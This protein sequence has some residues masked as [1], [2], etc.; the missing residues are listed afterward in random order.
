M[1]SVSSAIWTSGEPV[2]DS[3]TRVDGD[4]VVFLCSLQR[5]SGG[6]SSGRYL[7]V[8]FVVIGRIACRGSRHSA[9]VSVA[10]TITSRQSA[11]L[12]GLLLSFNKEG[13]MPRRARQAVRSQSSES[14]GEISMLGIIGGSGLYHLPG[15]DQ[16]RRSD[17]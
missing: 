2:S 6:A 3:W 14:V 7:A 13:T 8:L 4:D 5:H 12:I 16:M 17:T 11:R 1:R 9:F 10:R 15:L